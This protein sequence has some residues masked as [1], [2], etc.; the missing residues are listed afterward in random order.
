MSQCFKLFD[1]P[2]SSLKSPTNNNIQLASEYIA[3]LN[4]SGLLIAFSLAKRTTIFQA[5]NVTSFLWVSNSVI[6]TPILVLIQQNSVKYIQTGI[7]TESVP[8]DTQ[9]RISAFSINQLNESPWSLSDFPVQLNPK[10]LFSTD[11]NSFVL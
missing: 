3:W 8:F 1:L 6:Q 4:D 9:K 5:D 10:Y 11:L 7:I 2:D